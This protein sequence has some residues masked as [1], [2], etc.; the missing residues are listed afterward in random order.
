[1]SITSIKA[2]G[3]TQCF[4]A[5]EKN[6]VLQKIGHCEQ[7]HSPCSTFKVAISL[8]GYDS[9]ILKNESL[10]VYPYKGGSTVVEACKQSQTPASWMRNSCVWYS[11]DVTQKLGMEKFKNYL[12]KF[13]YGNQD[14]AGDNGKNN[15][16]TNA[17]LASSLEISPEEQVQF[18]KK[19]SEGKLPV[20]EK[21][22]RLTKQILFV[23]NL[24][25]G[26]KL[27]GKTGS[28]DKQTGWFVG[29]I[30]KDNRKIVFAH[31]IEGSQK[32]D[33]WGGRIA[34]EEARLKL[35]QLIKADKS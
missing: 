11:Q 32:S 14:A 28:K 4:L 26:W 31:Y 17:W 3:E 25:K 1:M 18:I 29:W 13:N 8:M 24:D 21:A 20:S 2:F 15:G 33:S 5:A 7:R 22:Q 34:K 9:G 16:L 12:K 6:Q 35:T 27:Y 10:P 23:D 19:L 30:E